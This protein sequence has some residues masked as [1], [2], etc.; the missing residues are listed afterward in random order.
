MEKKEVPDD[1]E[2]Y[3]TSSCDPL[4]SLPLRISHIHAGTSQLSWSWC[5]VSGVITSTRNVVL[6]VIMHLHVI[7]VAWIAD[8]PVSRNQNLYSEFLV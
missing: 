3:H 4:L 8:T 7:Q 6:D 1:T 2:A 5:R